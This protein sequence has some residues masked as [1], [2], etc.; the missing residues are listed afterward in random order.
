MNLMC[1]ACFLDEKS[2]KLKREGMDRM[3]VALAGSPPNCF[4]SLMGDFFGYQDSVPTPSDLA[5]TSS[6]PTPAPTSLPSMIRPKDP[7]AYQ[8]LPNL[9]SGPEYAT[10]PSK[11][12]QPAL[13]TPYQSGAKGVKPGTNQKHWSRTG[14]TA[15]FHPVSVEGEDLYKCPFTECNF[16]PHQ[17]LD[18]V[19]THIRHHLNLA[20]ACHYCNKLF[21]G[22]EGW[23]HHCKNVHSSYPPVPAGYNTLEEPPKDQD[24]LGDAVA[25]YEIADAE[26]AQAVKDIVNLLKSGSYDV[27]PDFVA[28][29][30]ES[31]DCQVVDDES[32]D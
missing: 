5:P 7:A 24:I 23:H 11:G 32:G 15:E 31:L 14:P 3:R 26:E 1:I 6:G 4:L 17:N 13:P 8:T 25:A 29:D 22:S 30:T 12:P 16:T 21:W 10:S 20:L 19:A 28:M 2:A 9:G 27:E 18:T